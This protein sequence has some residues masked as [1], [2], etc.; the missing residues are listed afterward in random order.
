MQAEIEDLGAVLQELGEPGTL[1]GWSYGG[2]IAL[3]AA[4]RQP[5]KHVIAYEPVVPPFGS[6]ALPALEAAARAA[7]WDRSVEI[8]NR[9]V[10]GFSAAHVDALRADHRK[11]ETLRR[12]SQP[13]YAETR[14]LSEAQVADV[15]ARR[16]ERVDLIVGEDNR[17]V[18]PYGTSFETVRD[19]VPHA[20]V[21]QLAGQGHMAHIE[22]PAA[23]GRLLNSLAPR[24]QHPPPRS[25]GDLTN[26]MP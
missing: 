23:L 15:M 24:E 22:A 2:L 13:L 14:A 20:A 18:T 16:A 9:D 17:G 3:L 26:A 11:W 5:M 19:R 12:L 1:F 7:D 6:H 10:S 25:P 4:D 8:V 21:H